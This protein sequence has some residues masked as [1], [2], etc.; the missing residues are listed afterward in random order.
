M[1]DITCPDAIFWPI[2]QFVQRSINGN[3]S[4]CDGLPFNKSIFEPHARVEVGELGCLKEN[5]PPCFTCQ[6]TTGIFHWTKTMS[7]SE[8][9]RCCFTVSFLCQ[10]TTVCQRK[11]PHW[12]SFILVMEFFH[13]K[14]QSVFDDQ[15][16]RRDVRKQFNPPTKHV[17][18]CNT[19]NTKL[20]CFERLDVL[21]A[22]LRLGFHSPDVVES[23]KTRSIALFQT[24]VSSKFPAMTN[25][26]PLACF[27]CSLWNVLKI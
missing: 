13:W 17:D 14:Q 16:L 20:P 9:C 21:A 1:G 19:D 8:S 12:L 18:N 15:S 5:T 24:R 25:S 22:Q 6:Q 10:K 3:G 4:C 7:E 11:E 2:P 26:W 27:L 23:S